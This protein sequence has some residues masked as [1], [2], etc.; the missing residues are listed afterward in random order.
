MRQW[1]IAKLYAVLGPGSTA[2]AE[3]AK[4]LGYTRLA[5]FRP[6][7]SRLRLLRTRSH[8]K[9]RIR[10]ARRRALS[11]QAWLQLDE[12]QRQRPRQQPRL[13]AL[14]RR[15]LLRQRYVWRDDRGGLGG[16]VFFAKFSNPDRMEFRC[17]RFRALGFVGLP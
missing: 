11:L 17:R 7:Q 14:R 16:K 9:G 13:L 3:A 10:G 6:P 5:R 4:R 15:S 12:A 8:M 1:A 2:S